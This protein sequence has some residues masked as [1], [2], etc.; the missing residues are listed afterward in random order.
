MNNEFIYEGMIE[1]MNTCS[2]YS[3]DPF[4]VWEEHATERVFKDR[5]F[6]SDAKISGFSPETIK[7]DL[8]KEL[9]SQVDTIESTWK[10]VNSPVQG[11]KMPHFTEVKFVI[12][13]PYKFK[14]YD[15]KIRKDIEV[16]VEACVQGSYNV[17]F[18]KKYQDD[19][20]YIWYNTCSC[21]KINKFLATKS[22]TFKSYILQGKMGFD[23]PYL[24]VETFVLALIKPSKFPITFN[25]FTEGGKKNVKFFYYNAP[26]KNMKITFYQYL[27]MFQAARKLSKMRG[28]VDL[29]EGKQLKSLLDISRREEK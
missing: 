5:D 20:S 3:S 22:P 8:L 1:R 12:R 16:M 10:S 15:N 11:K 14:Y 29:V 27:S 25:S 2:V 26:E 17:I 18:S 4:I 28:L 13:K 9:K 23:I 21:D 7:N 19:I 6:I 24:F